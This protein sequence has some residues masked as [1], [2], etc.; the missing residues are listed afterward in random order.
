MF[1]PLF[2]MDAS[3][4]S[5]FMQLAC[6]KHFSVEPLSFLCMGMLEEDREVCFIFFQT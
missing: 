3:T 6:S 4:K 2:L 5:K 1:F